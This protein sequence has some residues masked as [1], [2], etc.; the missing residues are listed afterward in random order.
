MKP[1]LADFKA[2]VP[3]SGSI[4]AFQVDPHVD[5]TR[6]LDL[7]PLVPADTLEAVELLSNLTV[8]DWPVPLAGVTAGALVAYRERVYEA[9]SVPAVGPPADG[10]S[11]NEWG[12]RPLPTLWWVYLRPFWV[13]QAFARFNRF[14]GKNFTKSGVTVPSDPQGTYVPASSTTRAELQQEANN[15]ASA[16]RNRLEVFLRD[17]FPRTEHDTCRTPPRR[18]RG[19]RSV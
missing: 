16:F 8:K 5:T 10:V 9:L 13:W 3:F 4:E 2:L 12:Y 11:T 14:H 19:L 6:V 1:T 17:A 7:L 15:T 18:R